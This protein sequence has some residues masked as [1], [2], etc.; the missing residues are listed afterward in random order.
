MI[1]APE[2]LEPQAQPAEITCTIVR[3]E[4][5]LDT[6]AAEWGDLLRRAAAARPQVYHT[7]A[8]LRYVLR[9]RPEAQP[10]VVLM[11][12]GGELLGLAPFLFEATRF[13]VRFSVRTLARPSGRRL[14]MVAA[15]PLFAPGAPAGQMAAILLQLLFRQQTDFDFAYLEWLFLDDPLLFELE[16]N[17]RI[18]LFVPP[19]QRQLCRQVILEG[20]YEQYTARWPKKIRQNYRRHRKKLEEHCEGDV[21][22]RTYTSPADLV[23]FAEHLDTIFNRTWQAHTYGRRK[24][25]TQGE[26]DSLA[27]IAEQGWLRSYVLMCKGA[28]VAFQHGFEFMGVYQGEETGYDRDWARFGAGSVL[29][30]S[31]VRDLFSTGR[32]HVLD[33]G[34]GDSEYKREFGNAERPACQAY[35]ALNP[36]WKSILR[37]Q[38]AA[39]RVYRFGHRIVSKAGIAKAI[40]A[41]LKNKKAVPATQ[42]AANGE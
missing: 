6:V 33:W 24:R 28:P 10:Y 31:V 9:N 30:D 38:A 32:V 3:D 14:R 41:R 19:A 35:F 1:A 22:I 12:H 4:A 42:P 15:G 16:Q 13:R 11:W 17:N 2:L 21:Q 23:E 27:A 39:D 5:G 37:G 7:P 29:L 36:K 25:N 18:N 26:I 40:R 8:F 34:F 20:D